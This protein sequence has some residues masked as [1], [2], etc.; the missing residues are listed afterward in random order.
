[1]E[2]QRLESLKMISSRKSA[3]KKLFPRHLSDS[4]NIGV[5]EDFWG[6]HSNGVPAETKNTNFFQAAKESDTLK[7][8]KMGGLLHK[9]NILNLPVSGKE[10]K[11]TQK[12]VR[13]APL[14]EPL[15]TK[16]ECQVVLSSRDMDCSIV[17][18]L[19]GSSSDNAGM[20]PS[21]QSIQSP[22]VSN[23]ADSPV[24]NEAPFIDT[25]MAK[26]L[27]L[28]TFL[29]Y[30]Q[31]SSHIK[32]AHGVVHTMNEASVTNV[33]GIVP[34]VLQ[35]KQGTTVT[36]LKLPALTQCHILPNNKSRNVTANRIGGSMLV[37]S[38]PVVPEQT[39]NLVSPDAGGIAAGTLPVAE[40]YEA[41]CI[42]NVVQ[43]VPLCNS[44]VS[45]VKQ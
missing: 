22:S 19:N 27:H 29:Q 35:V 1:M 45:L 37:P 6:S 3:R 15:F 39:N 30:I 17:H 26:P 18:D 23:M 7:T 10:L 38:L 32:L 41:V 36:E 25:T 21:S 24:L 9:S 43:L 31:S 14:E 4:C 33:G 20:K 16:R 8:Q 28:N 40:L 13:V 12:L 42:G 44:S 2:L 5:R 11:M 34:R